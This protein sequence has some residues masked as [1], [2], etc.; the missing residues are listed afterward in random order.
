MHLT[1]GLQ[2]GPYEIVAPIGAGGIG[3]VYRAHDSRLSRQVAI[4]VLHAD[5]GGDPARL[6]RFE[7]EARTAGSLDHPNLVTVFDIG[8]QDG[9]PYIVFEL[10]RGTTLRACLDKGPLPARTAFAY[11]IQIASGLSAAHEKG[12]VHRDLKPANVFVTKDGRVKILDFGLARLRSSSVEYDGAEANTSSAITGP[13]AMVGTVG[14]MSPEQAVGLPVD[15]RSDIFSFGAL[16]YELLSGR[17][18]FGGDSP[19]AT[20]AAILKEDPLPLAGPSVAALPGLERIA[21]QCLVKDREKRFQSARDLVFA[22]EAASTVPAESGAGMR[23]PRRPRKGLALAMAAVV[24]GLLGLAVLLGRSSTPPPPL[25]DRLTYRRGFVVSARFTPDGENLVYGAAWDGE[26][27]RLFSTR[28]GSTESRP[29]DLPPADIFAISSRGEMAVSLGCQRLAGFNE[30]VGTLAR[31]SF[32]GG[33]PRELV[34]DVLG[35]DWSPDGKDLAVVRVIKERGP[36]LRL[37]MPLGNVLFEGRAAHPRVS[38]RGDLV[39]FFD[40]SDEPTGSLRVV[41]RKGKVRTLLTGRYGSCTGVAWSRAGDEVWMTAYDADNRTWLRGVS[42]RGR[43]RVVHAD[44]SRLTILD[45]GPRGALMARFDVRFSTNGLVPGAETE[46][47]LSWFASSLPT[48]VSRDGKTLLFVERGEAG[49]GQSGVFARRM[50]GSPAVRLGEGWH[51]R[52]SPDAKRVAALSSEFKTI[53]I[54][55][56]G[57]GDT[58]TIS[59]GELRGHAVDWRPDGKAIL[60]VGAQPGRPARTYL[61]DLEGGSPTPIT[62]EGSA[63]SLPSPDGK[64]V[65]ARSADEGLELHSLEGGLPRPIPG[66]MAQDDPVSWSPDGKSLWMIRTEPWR[67]TLSRLDL[68]T[69]RRSQLRTVAPADP[70]GIIRFADPFVA[71]PDGRYYAYGVWR[72]MNELYLV[73]GLR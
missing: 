8:S 66:V 2:L 60:F 64:F 51:G 9:T 16:L 56:T 52:L 10:L 7:Q 13:G 38:P 29:L 14:Y 26:P 40:A 28:V 21:W 15:H 11:A 65:V 3:E 22:L 62:P 57:P 44:A 61:Q 49:R 23:P 73:T 71:T 67:F 48:D 45:V 59:L 34:K 12:I 41:D 68:T 50:D 25:F 53:V 27:V 5:V 42:L 69:G 18:A 32:A 70:A 47:D 36:R 72:V 39:A 33:A 35:A 30:C 1:S 6:R 31:A 19:V 55:P 20:T 43:E 24:A 46:R 17:R 4:K 54:M 58:K 37:E 63:G